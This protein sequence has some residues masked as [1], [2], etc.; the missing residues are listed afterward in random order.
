M[1]S[2]YKHNQTGQLFAIETDEAGC[3]LSVCGPMKETS[4]DPRA[5]DYDDYWNWQST[6]DLADYTRLSQDDYLKLLK[7]NGYFPNL[8]QECL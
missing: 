3:I 6:N 8:S 5:L 4:L 1:K 7:D 2:I